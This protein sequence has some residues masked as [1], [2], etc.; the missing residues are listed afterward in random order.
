MGKIQVVVRRL[1]A[2]LPLVLLSACTLLVD[3]GALRGGGDAD[4]TDLVT[5]REG[6]PPQTIAKDG[7]T[8]DGAGGD[9]AIGTSPCAAAHTFCDDFDTGN[10]SLATR[11]SE[12]R[13]GAGPLVLDTTRSRSAPRSLRMDLTPTTGTQDSQL[14]KTVTVPNAAARL[15][16]DIFIPTPAAD[17]GTYTEVDPIGVKLY[18]TPPG[19]NFH[20]LYLIIRSGKTQLQYFAQKKDANVDN[21]APV[22]MTMD[23]WHHV[24]VTFSYATTPPKGTIAVDGDVAS[25]EMIG[26]TPTKLDY[27]LGAGYTEN[28]NLNWSLSFDNA[29]VDVP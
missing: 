7:G 10:G 6:G 5:P 13:T 15:E 2:A 8:T 9:A 14:A 4:A 19:Y 27:E 21:R 12:L 1:A 18:P 3:V 16:V 25:V 24:V 29:V 23:A 11:W 20:G 17:A 26:P 22:T 28:A